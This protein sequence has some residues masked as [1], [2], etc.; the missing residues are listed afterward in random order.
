MPTQTSRKSN[1]FYP[2]GARVSVKMKNDPNWYD[3]G[4]IGSAVTNTINWTESTYETANAGKLDKKVSAMEISGGFTLINLDPVGIGKMGGGLFDIETIKAEPTEFEDVNL[5]AGIKE[6]E[7]YAL[8]LM[9]HQLECGLEP[10]PID[11]PLTH[12]PKFTVYKVDESTTPVTKTEI[13]EYDDSDPEDIVEGWILERDSFDGLYSIKFSEDQ[14][15]NLPILIEFDGTATENTPVAR[16]VVNAGSSSVVME[17]FA[18]KIDH[19]DDNGKHRTLELYSVSSNTGGF[20]F[21]FK[22]ANEDGV[23]EMPLTYTAIL[24]TTRLSKRQLMSFAV[25]E[26]AS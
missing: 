8:P 4:A 21:N 16:T 7:S 25:E 11:A 14:D 23:E 24:D 2:D 20:Q 9:Y 26:G 5:P 12:K 10:D 22:G 13:P 6:S 3:V 19:T 17:P 18:M 15:A 1:I